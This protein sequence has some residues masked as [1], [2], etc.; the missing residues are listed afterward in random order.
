MRSEQLTR[1]EKNAA[2]LRDRAEYERRRDH[3]R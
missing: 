1:A 3:N 2:E